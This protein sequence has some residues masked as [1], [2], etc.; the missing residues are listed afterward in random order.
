MTNLVRSS[1][2]YLTADER[3]VV[4]ATMWN[5]GYTPLSIDLSTQSFGTLGDSA[6]LRGELVTL[7]D[8]GEVQQPFR[9]GDGVEMVRRGTGGWTFRANG[10][11]IPTPSRV[12]ATKRNTL[13]AGAN[14]GA[15]TGSGTEYLLEIDGTTGASRSN[16]VGNFRPLLSEHSGIGRWSDDFVEPAVEAVCS[17]QFRE[18]NHG[19]HR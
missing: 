6:R 8:G 10:R 7:S 12:L 11:S 9:V 4:T 3:S 5:A 13:L 2:L 1:A 15:A 14:T 18:K 19:D 17:A 16:K